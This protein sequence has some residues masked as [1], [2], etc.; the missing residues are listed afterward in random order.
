MPLGTM[1]AF[2]TQPLGNPL[3]KKKPVPGAVT[4]GANTLAPAPGV[5]Q[6]GVMGN[7]NPMAALT[8]QPGGPL[9][10][11]APAA[12]RPLPQS[13]PTNP[14]ASLVQRGPMG[15]GTGITPAAAAT[16]APIV[17][18]QPA[19]VQPTAGATAPKGG[20]SMRTL[21]VQPASSTTTGGRM[22]AP[23]V[24]PEAVAGQGHQ[25]DPGADKGPIPAPP[26]TTTPPPVGYDYSSGGPNEQ[27]GPPEGFFDN[28]AYSQYIDPTTGMISSFPMDQAAMNQWIADAGLAD[29]PK[30]AGWLSGIGKA[31]AKL[32][33]AIEQ[34]GSDFANTT[35]YKTNLKY[36]NDLVGNLSG[37]GW[38][39]DVNALVGG[40][41]GGD[42]GA[43]DGGGG[44][45]SAGPGSSLGDALNPGGIDPTTGR[46]ILASSNPGAFSI[47][48]WMQNMDPALAASMM[49]WL[50]GQQKQANQ[51]TAVDYYGGYMD[52][53]NN[54]PTRG[55][56]G[57]WLGQGPQYT[58]SPEVVD[59]MK[60]SGRSLAGSQAAEAERLTRNNAASLGQPTSTGA[61][62]LL[63][64]R[65][66]IYG[67]L[68][69]G[70][71]Q[72]DIEAAK[73]KA[74][75]EERYWNELLGGNAALVGPMGGAYGSMASLITGG[76]PNVGNPMQGM[77]DYR[78]QQQQM[79]PGAMK[80]R[81]WLATG[82]GFGGAALGGLF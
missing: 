40:L 4:P 78:L 8:T 64:A 70:N 41:T 24:P 74:A 46:P 17:P 60:A 25:D 28:P 7:N 21:A 11:A 69:Q 9:P 59:A 50:T 23:E 1:A 29:N 2:A 55:A 16:A 68:A 27:K 71:N 53:L 39:F 13:Q 77:A 82:A 12:G 34:G 56:I 48:N 42:G 10:S 6:P 26:S 65:A 73:Q 5:S 66:D 72:I 18:P 49:D 45:A 20:E 63:R 58:L 37:H 44:G 54:D 79:D 76:L 22:G 19:P 67:N 30:V 62:T 51:Q 57:D 61:G 35:A 33:A 15:G 43:T 31:M 38:N 52:Y 80:A 14:M 75:D 32:Q 81:D 47:P 36:L 3:A